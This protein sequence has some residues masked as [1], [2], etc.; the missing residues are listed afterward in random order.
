MVGLNGRYDQVR[1]QILRKEMLCL[2]EVISLVSVEE[3]KIVVI[4]GPCTT[5]ALQ[6]LLW[7]LNHITRKRSPVTVR[8]QLLAGKAKTIFGIPSAR[9]LDTPRKMLKV[10]WKATT[11]SKN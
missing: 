3:N 4:L 11:S 8:T 10:L 6:Q 5:I 2:N 7:T 9:S 1:V